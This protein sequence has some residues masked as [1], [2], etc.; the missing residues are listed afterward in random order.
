MRKYITLFFSV[1]LFLSACDWDGTPS[2]IIKPEQMTALL[3]DVHIAD[4]SMMN[5]TQQRDSLY[6]YGTAK[7]SAAFEKHH[8]DSVQ[9]KKSFKYYTMHPGVLA[10]IYVSVLNKLKLKSDSL[11]N[12][13]AKQNVSDAKNK[14]FRTSR[15]V[16]GLMGHVPVPV[17]P[18]VYKNAQIFQKKRARAWAIRDSIAKRNSKIHALPKQQH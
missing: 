13:V 16:G 14:V 7:F 4:G 12:L 2:G 6:K 8:T 11:T 15:P 3:I 1:T 18:V 9:F 10:A 5:M 17:N